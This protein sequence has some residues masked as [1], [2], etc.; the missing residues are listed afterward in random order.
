MRF[1]TFP[2][3]RVFS[4]VSGYSVRFRWIRVDESQIRNKMFADIS[5][6]EHVWTGPQIDLK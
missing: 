1:Q 4:R 6:S 5:E 2:L 3:W